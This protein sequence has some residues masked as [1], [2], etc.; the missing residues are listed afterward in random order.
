MNLTKKRPV[1][2]LIIDIILFTAFL[3]LYEEHA[4]GSPV[5]EWLGITLAV[6]MTIHII[7]HWRWITCLF[8]NFFGKLSVVNRIKLLLNILI[9]FSFSTIV[10][11]GIKMSRQVLPVLGV[12]THG[13]SFWKWLHFT[14]VDLTVWFTALHIALNWKG[15]VKI[16]RSVFI[17]SPVNSINYP[18]ESVRITRNNRHTGFTYSSSIYKYFLNSMII[19]LLAGSIAFFWYGFSLTPTAYS[20]TFHPVHERFN[21]NRLNSL[22]PDRHEEF[23]RQQPGHRHERRNGGRHHDVSFIGIW[24]GIIKNV[25]IISIVTF[26]VTLTGYGIRKSNSIHTKIVKAKLRGK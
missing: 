17:K 25:L 20:G 24:P 12:I 13:A 10:F 3:V 8:K 15:I 7:F 19:L 6:L 23:F 16:F 18:T 11:S 2:D 9:F 4:T 1:K 22:E 14:A 5:H 26:G 21:N